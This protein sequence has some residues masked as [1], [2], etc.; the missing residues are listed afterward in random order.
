MTLSA[1]SRVGPYEIVGLIGSGGMGEVYRAR[2][3]TLN[4]D[5]ALKVLPEHFASDP[6]RLARFRR[7]AQL[8]ASLN[9]PNIAAI[10]GFEESSGIHALV[11][12]LVEGPTLAERIG[13]GTSHKA[14]GPSYNSLPLDE[15]LAIAKQIADALEAAHEQGVIH[16]DLKPANIKVRSDG[17]VKVLDFGLAKAFEPEPAGVAGSSMA[18]TITSPA[19]TR[20]GTILGTAAYMSPEQARGKPVD[21]R[22]DIWAFG[23]VLYEMLTG[24]RPFEGEEITDVLAR[25]LERDPDFTAISEATPPAVQ[26]LLRR[27]LDKDRKRRLPDIG[28]ARLEIDDALAAPAGARASAVTV[29]TSSRRERAVWAGTVVMGAAITATGAYYM[30]PAPTDAPEMRLQID[31]PGGV[32]INTFAVSPDGR[33]V[34]FRSAAEG[35]EPQLWIRSLASE[36]AQPLAGTEQASTPFWSPDSRSIGFFLRG[37][38]KRLDLADGRIQ[39]LASESGPGGMAWSADGTILFARSFSGPLYRVAAAGGEVA[40]VTRVDPPRH[41]GHVYPQF[42]PDGRRFIFFAFGSPEGEGVY[43]GSLDSAEVRRLFRAESA[44]VFAPPD[45]L[46]F[47]QEG[48]LVAQRLDLDTWQLAGEPRTV[49][50]QVLV[51][52]VNGYSAVSASAAGPIAYRSQP[53][54]RQFVWLD[55]SGRRMGTLGESDPAQPGAVRLTT[56]GRTAALTRTIEGNTDIWLMDIVRGNLRRLTVDPAADTLPRWSPD[57]S[58][59]VFSS[60]RRA[61]NLD[62]YE[63]VVNGAEPERLLLETPTDKAANDWSPDGRFVLFRNTDPKTAADLWALP[64]FGDR[65]PFPVAQGPP[66][67]NFGRFSPDGRWVAYQSNESGRFEIYVQPF[68]GPGPRVQVSTDGGTNP[69]WRG[70]GRELFLTTLENRLMVSAVRF[71]G[72]G[73]EVGTPE[74]LFLKPEGTWTVSRDGQRFLVAATTEEASPITILLNWAGARQAR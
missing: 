11:M 62:L 4:R 27:C 2:D 14:Q 66:A 44:A 25:I 45:L 56:D 48:A 69:E 1:R 64:L 36:A 40:E 49:A 54:E 9:H 33:S 51:D 67:E 43:L 12:E 17:M 68:P 65:K 72:S 30:Q 7:E 59:I 29:S 42:L 61:G 8:L 35:S 24:R 22:T 71:V 50:R 20:L 46:V 32:G 5:V 16:R 34:V 70:D 18:P 52:V 31:R 26:R 73:I 41:S 3:T 19:A 63:R 23:C 28:V 39:T 10:Y 55:R 57:A 58:R 6:E 60:D 74:A 15:T 38:L 47:A 53:G 13:Q 21:K 37:E